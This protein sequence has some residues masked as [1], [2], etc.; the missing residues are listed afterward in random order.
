MR[1]AHRPWTAR[2]LAVLL[3]FLLVLAACTGFPASGPDR[4]DD[5][6][7]AFV[8]E[9]AGSPAPDGAST[10]PSVRSLSDLVCRD[11]YTPTALD[12]IFLG[13]VNA[14]GIASGY[15]YEGF[16][17]SLGRVVPGTRTE[18]DEDGI[19]EARVEVNGVAK[20]G[21][22]G[23]STFFPRDWPPQEVVDAIEAAYDSRV[24]VDGNIWAGAGGGIGIL[25]YLD[26]EERI[27]S[28]F[29]DRGG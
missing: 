23:R 6:G 22:R 19:Y 4:P 26:E 16:P 14:R 11:I 17:D 15:H 10:S 27:I 21:N 2:W 13:T 1:A 7:G 8:T 20:S 3:P 24:H 18:P 5:A 28:A 9:P 25:M 12:H 29:P